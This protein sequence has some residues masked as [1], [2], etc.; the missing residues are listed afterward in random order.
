[1]DDNLFVVRIFGLAVP[2]SA[3]NNISTCGNIVSRRKVNRNI[4]RYRRHEA[5]KVKYFDVISDNYW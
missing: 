5:D 1:M 2:G 4:S 3:G